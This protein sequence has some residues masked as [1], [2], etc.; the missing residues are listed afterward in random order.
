MDDP[1]IFYDCKPLWFEVAGK[2][3]YQKWETKSM[4]WI[5]T[6]N[7]SIWEISLFLLK[8]QTFPFL[9]FLL[10]ALPVLFHLYNGCSKNIKL[11]WKVSFFEGKKVE[12]CMWPEFEFV[13]GFRWACSFPNK[14]NRKL[15]R[16][17]FNDF[18]AASSRLELSVVL[19]SD[20]LLSLFWSQCFF[21]L[22]VDDI[23]AHIFF[24]TNSNWRRRR[25]IETRF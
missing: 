17:F 20:F 2:Y 12:I 8:L 5:Y 23:S 24:L 11:E 18:S 9:K 15:L 16:N 3:K 7:V 21:T 6:P 1:E 19:L 14:L 10:K 4:D 13:S 25:K 22:N